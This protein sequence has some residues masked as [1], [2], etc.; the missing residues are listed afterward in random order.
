MRCR[1]A[2]ARRRALVNHLRRW[3]R[4]PVVGFLTRCARIA[5]PIAARC[6][7]G[8][9]IRKDFDPKIGLPSSSSAR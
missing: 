6:S 9:F 3:P 5:R 4:H 8:D 1:S 7:G 2:G